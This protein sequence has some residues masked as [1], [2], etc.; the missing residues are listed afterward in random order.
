MFSLTSL[1]EDIFNF[2]L[3]HLT[4]DSFLSLSCVNKSAHAFFC[5]RNSRLILT[6]KKLERKTKNVAQ[7]Y[8][9][10]S[11]IPNSYS[12]TAT[13]RGY[14]IVNDQI[15]FME[16]DDLHTIYR[17]SGLDST[18]IFYTFPP[19][20]GLQ[21]FTICDHK[22]LVAL[23]RTDVLV[24]G[25]ALIVSIPLSNPQKP[26]SFR[27]RVETLD[28]YTL[29]W[30][31]KLLPGPTGC[32]YLHLIQVKE[33]RK[34]HVLYLYNYVELGLKTIHDCLK[35]SWIDYTNAE[36]NLYFISRFQVLLGESSQC[37]NFYCPS[38]TFLTCVKRKSKRIK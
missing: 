19:D 1:S 21:S 11:P 25:G 33:N 38:G 20:I 35:K 37:F 24:P 7:M 26:I 15:F 4:Y 12:Y 32:F 34:Y 3:F 27:I 18:Q 28:W 8:T 31:A 14:G 10:L 29:H 16:M 17:R 30:H 23:V 5:L 9:F 2:V 22:T 36:Y 6:L 13:S